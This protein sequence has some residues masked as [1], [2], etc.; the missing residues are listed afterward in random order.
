MYSQQV[1][2]KGRLVG[3]SLSCDQRECS[4]LAAP[5]LWLSWYLSFRATLWA[6]PGGTCD[7][8]SIHM[9]AVSLGD[10]GVA[11]TAVMLCSGACIP[12]VF[13]SCTASQSL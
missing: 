12:E 13:H 1:A 9:D 7:L 6:S 4:G 3:T 8:F 10:I 5:S 2:L 11:V